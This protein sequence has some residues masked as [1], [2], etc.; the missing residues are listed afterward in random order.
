[1]R[2]DVKAGILLGVVLVAAAIVY[3][4]NNA[5]NNG[6]ELADSGPPTTATPSK[7]VETEQIPES[8]PDMKPEPDPEPTTEPKQEPTPEPATESRREPAPEPAPV[9][10][11]ASDLAPEPEPVPQAEPMDTRPRYYTVKKG[12]TLYKISEHVYGEGKYWKAIYQANKNLISNPGTL[13]P[14][15]KL[16]LP[17]PEGL[18]D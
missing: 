10:D 16:K 7:I 11:V 4:A 12:D 17:R 9:P 13:Q 6:D 18:T 8:E 14:A 5:D 3:F 2:T 15:W 1:M